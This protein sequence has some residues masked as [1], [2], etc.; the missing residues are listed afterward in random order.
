MLTVY[1]IYLITNNLN[2][3]TYI[4]KH[5]CDKN[6][7]PESRSYMGGGINIRRAENKYGM[8]NFSKS[9]LAIC[10]S[11]EEYNIL[12]KVYIKLYRDVGKAEYNIAEGGDGGNTFKYK[13]KEEMKIIGEKISKAGKGR[14]GAM[15]GKHLSLETRNKISEGVKK[16]FENEEI[17]EKIR[18]NT[19]RHIFTPEERMQISLRN[20]GR[21]F[22]EEFRKRVSE[23]C[24][25][26]KNTL[27]HHWYTDGVNNTLSLECPEGY[28]KGISGR[29]PLSK[30]TKEKISNTLKGR[31]IS[32][33]YKMKCSLN[34]VGRK[35]FNN[36][37]NE[38]FL[39]KCPEGYVEGRIPRGT[40]W[41]KGKTNCFS[42][43]T[44][45]KMRNSSCRGKHYYN[46]G[47]IEVREYI[48]PEGFEPGRLK[49]ERKSTTGYHWYNNGVINVS[50]KECPEG[51][52]P[53][54]IISW[55]I[56][57]LNAN[58]KR[59]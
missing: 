38:R 26:N 27:G 28:Y 25:N 47:I 43:E 8:E 5:K 3:K 51:F 56:F 42:K 20:K 2:G 58:K 44:I 23:A 19:T 13:T 48:C 4:G 6:E 54:R 29:K 12:E 24:K 37:I 59:K 9:I 11:E 46:N 15:K 35:W 1:S 21:K 16:A 33:E 18:R 40:C 50:A 22:S 39:Y 14:P 30:E 55:E 34:G 32:E 52:H 10:Y 36:G 57:D 41:N 7:E 45:E 17:I 31:P 49:I 53:G